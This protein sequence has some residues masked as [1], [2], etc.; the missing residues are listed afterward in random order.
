MSAPIPSTAASRK[1]QLA[2]TLI[3]LLVVIAII[4]ILAAMLLPALS[5]AKDRAKSSQCLSNLRQW[6]IALQIYVV[7]SRDMIPR[8]GTDNNKQYA[9]D[10]GATT[11]Q[12][13]PNDEFAW[14]NALP[15]LV[16]E[17]PFSVYWNA[18]G[19]NMTQK[20]PW[21]GAQGKFFECPAII[22]DTSETFIAGGQYGFWS[23][24]MNLDLKATTSLSA[25]GA[26]SALPWPAEPKL[27]AVP[28]PVATVLLTEMAFSPTHESLVIGPDRNGIFPSERSTKF[29]Y[30]HNSNKGGNLVFLD[31]HSSYFKRSYITNGFADAGTT[32][33]AEKCNPDVIWDLY[34]DCP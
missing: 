12:G 2:F 19:G 24:G 10:T 25:S 30:R 14:F 27:S 22:G 29:P 21:P 16:A 7:D 8:D 6:G 28:K 15:P 26:Y 18:P 11:G 31:G 9:V 13:S 20:L 23:Y 33:R 1:M 17:K 3:E 32:H 5:R 4:A 34:R